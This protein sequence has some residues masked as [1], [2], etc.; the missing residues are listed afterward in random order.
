MLRRL[1]PQGPLGQ[2]RVRAGLGFSRLQFWKEEQG[3]SVY[4]CLLL[5]SEV[6]SFCRP[7]SELQP[8]I[9]IS[10]VYWGRTL[11]ASEWVSVAATCPAQIFPI[12]PPFPLG[13]CS[14]HALTWL[15]RSS[16]SVASFMS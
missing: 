9:R 8:C 12:F 7:R 10:E 14:S 15:S 13:A 1:G 5:L 2:G 16:S 3:K 4:S 6:N 11:M